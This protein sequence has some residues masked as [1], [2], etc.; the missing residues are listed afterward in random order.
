LVSSHAAPQVRVDSRLVRPGDIFV[1]VKGATCDGHDF[2]D[3][4]LA[5]GAG[6]IVCQDDRGAAGAQARIAVRDPARAV[7]LLA[8]AAKGN[9]AARLTNLA[10]TGTNGKTTVA[11][12]GAACWE[13]LSTTPVQVLCPHR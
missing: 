4:A 6:Y 1:A 10:V 3:Q 9:P 13:R 2:I 7:G 8:Q 5:N 12:G 11:A